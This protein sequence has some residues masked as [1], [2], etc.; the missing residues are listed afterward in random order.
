MINALV[1]KELKS[2]NLFKFYGVK[3]LIAEKLER[4]KL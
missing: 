4:L 1:F 3:R 2:S